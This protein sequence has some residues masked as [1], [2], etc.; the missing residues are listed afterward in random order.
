[1]DIATK[2][3]HVLAGNSVA[4]RPLTAVRRLINGLVDHNLVCLPALSP[5]TEN[6][7]PGVSTV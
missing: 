2:G 5:T 4:S 6:D 3:A 7:L 1:M